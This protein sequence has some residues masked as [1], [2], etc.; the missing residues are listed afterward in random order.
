MELCKEDQLGEFIIDPSAGDRITTAAIH[1]KD[2]ERPAPKLLV[3]ETGYYCVDTQPLGGYDYQAVVEFRNAYG[4]LPGAQ[5]P[6]LAFYGALAIVYAVICAFWGFLY[7]QNR[8]DILPVQNYIT[9]TLAFLV[10]EMLVTW[11]YYDYMNRHGMNAG[12]KALLVVDSILNAGRNSLSFF[13]LLIV[14]MGYG[15]V[16]PSLGDLMKWIRGL[17]ITHFVFGVVY[18][19]GSLTVKPEDAGPLVLLVV[20]PLAATGTAFYVWTLNSLGKTLKDLVDRKQ[21]VKALMYRKLWWCILI[22]IMVIFGFF[23]LN[24]M[25]FSGRGAEDFTPTHWKSRWFVLDGWLSLVYL[26]DVAFIAYLWRPTANNRR[27]AMSEEI[28]QDD[29]GFEI[30]SVRDSLDDMD[31]EEVRAA[32]EDGGWGKQGPPATKLGQSNGHAEEPLPAPTP[33]RPPGVMR[34]SA[35]DLD[36]ETI[37]AVGEDAASESGDEGERQGLTK[38]RRDS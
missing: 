12:A 8:S 7:W 20:F 16:K 32:G 35:D 33:Q 25:F 10:I 17:A 31:E 21:R 27:F 29:E 19:I 5:I 9:A 3:K 37:F 11:G 14:C 4:E 23:L 13:L 2:S 24:L 6:K 26:A 18:A 15:V 1:T 36:G 38:A 30:A 22:S 28:N 34:P